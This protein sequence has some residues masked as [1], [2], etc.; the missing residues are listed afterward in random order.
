M[1]PPTDDELRVDVEELKASTEAYKRQTEFLRR[2]KEGLE[3]LKKREQGVVDAKKKLRERRRKKWVLERDRLLTEIENVTVL[4]RGQLEELQKD[5]GSGGVKAAAV[6]AGLAD[7]DSLSEVLAGDD[8]VLE[9]LERLAEETNAGDLEEGKE[10]DVV[11]RVRKMT[12]K[13]V[14]SSTRI[15]H[16]CFHTC[17]L[18]SGR[19][20][21]DDRLGSL[22]TQAVRHRLDRI[23]LETLAAE[24]PSHAGKVIPDIAQQ[25]EYIK[26]LK[27]DLESLDAEIPTVAKMSAE[28]EFLKPVV[29]EVQKRKG[30][31]EEVIGG[32]GG[33]V[34]L[35]P[36][37]L[38]EGTRTLTVESNR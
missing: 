27:A 15:F 20:W 38:A 10:G 25:E 1:L 12:L 21:T 2:Q 6:G 24:Q 17:G 18:M 33:Y 19:L 7:L 30:M 31:L 14:Y 36:F 37:N 28:A 29:G 34:C 11:E 8:K 9:K 13:Y 22:M 16:L 26:T 3:A 4:L 23:Y 5:V 32:R 35:L